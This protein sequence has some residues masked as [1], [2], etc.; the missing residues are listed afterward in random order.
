MS[1]FSGSGEQSRKINDVVTGAGNSS[2][3]NKYNDNNNDTSS[4]ARTTQQQQSSSNN[5]NGFTIPS[6]SLPK[7][8][9]AIRGIGEKF[10]ANPVTGTGSLSVPIYTSPGRSGFGPSLSLSY[11]SG[12]GNSPF[13]F[14]WSLSLPSITRKTS[15]GIPKYQDADESDVFIL[16]GAEDLVP[17][18]KKNGNG[19]FEK[20]AHRN[21][22]IDE[23]D[24]DG[25][26][27]RK[28]RPRTEGLFARIERWTHKTNGDIHWRSIS[29]D[30]ILTVYGKSR[31]SRIADPSDESGRVYSW[32]ICESY[33]D[34]GNA[35]VYE[36]AEEDEKGIEDDLLNI[37]ERN[38][39]RTANR[40][41]K[42]IFYGNRRPLLLDPTKA[43]F[44]KSHIELSEDDFS[45]ADWMFEVVFDY[46]EGH[47]K[48]IPFDSNIP[49]DEQHQLVEAAASAGSIWSGRPDTFSTYRSSFE[50]RTYRRCHRV[51]MFHH[52]R[53]L[54]TE[55]Y[56]VRSTEFDYLDFDYSSRSSSSFTVSDELNDKGSTRFASFIQSVVQ[57]GYLKDETRPIHEVNGVKYLI[58]IKKSIP[59]LEF[60]YSKCVI[61]HD[62]KDLDETS[63]ENLP[64]GIDGSGYQLVDLDG[65]GVSG[66]LTE[67]ADTWFYKPNLGDAKFGPIEVVRT[68]P[69]ISD[70]NG[71]RQQLMDLAG[72]GQLDL[73]EMR[74]TSPGFYE[75]THDRNW[76]N[77][78]PFQSIPNVS[79]NDPNLR[80]VDL[81]GDGHAD[82]LITENEVFTWYQSL[83]EKG[84]ESSTMVFQEPDEEKGPKLVLNESS[85]SIYLADMSG[86]GLSDLVRIKNGEVCY[87]PNL[88]YG[89]FGAKVTMDNSPWFDSPDQFDSKKIRLADIDGS[90]VTDI[91]YIG[92]T[93]D[94]GAIQIYFNQSGNRWSDVYHLGLGLQIDNHSSIQ[95]T[96]LFG[97]GTA[98]LVWSSPLAGHSR[99]SLRYLD[100]MGGTNPPDLT[101]GTKPHLLVKSVNNLGAETRV[102][103][104]SSTK[105]YLEDKAAGKPWITSMPFPVHVIERVE[106]YDYISR[107][108]FVTKYAYHHGYF[109]GIEQEFRGFG[110]VEQLDT[111]NFATLGNN[112]SMP[113][114]ENIDVES[115]IP[116]VLTKTWFHTGVYHGRDHVSDYFVGEYYR[117]PEL[118]Q[119]PTEA[120]KR[121]LDDT[122]MPAEL[123]VDEEYEACRALRGSMLRQE[124]FSRDGTEKE[125][126]PY[127]VTE[128]NFTIRTVQPRGRNRHTVFLTHEKEALTY[129]Y[130]RNPKDPRISHMMTL[131]VDDFGNVLKQAQIGY[132][133]E[134]LDPDLPRQEDQLNQT[135]TSVIY[136]E[137]RVTKDVDKMDAYRTPLPCES[138][139]YE[140]TGYSYKDEV[141]RFIDSDFVKPDPTRPNR[142]ILDFDG[143]DVKYEDI[144]TSGKRRRPIEHIRTFYRKNDLS[145]ILSLEEMESLALPGDIY[146]LA[147][148]PGLI[149][150]VYRRSDPDQPNVIDNLLP[151]PAEVLEGHG[152]G[153]GGYVSSQE[154]KAD[155][156]F[157]GDDPDDHWW[158]PSCRI[159]FSPNND[160]TTLDELTYAVEHFYLPHR[161]KNPFGNTTIV[162]FDLENFLLIVKVEDP[163][164]NVVTVGGM[165][166]RLL[167]PFLVTNPN[168]NRSMVAFDVLG[169]VVG[170]AV[171]G[172]PDPANPEG[173]NLD[174][175]NSNLT[176]KEIRDHIIV[177][178][179]DPHSILRNATTRMIYD[180]FSYYNT[181]TQPHPKPCV[182]YAMVRETHFADPSNG[183]QQDTKIQH[184]FSYSDGF[185][186][187]IQKKIQAEIGP[188][189]L[190]DPSSP[191]ADPRWVGTG[192]TIF[193]NKG[194][195]VRQYEPFFSDTSDFEFKR[196]EGVSPVIFY[197]PVG[198]SVVVLHPNDTYEK[199]VFDNWNQVTSDV[200][201][202]VLLD[203]RTDLDVSGIVS[204][205]F[206]SLSDPTVWK[207]WYQK[208]ITDPSFS[209]DEKA[210]ARKTES[211]ANTPTTTFFDSLGRP[212][213]TFS[214][215]G[216]NSDGY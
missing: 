6:I 62:I 185:G 89:R 215:N 194:K 2:K 170:M 156:L 75:R 145:A 91:L 160:D 45:S 179:N 133:R 159:F 137:N 107:N 128:Q 44:R 126:N 162:T 134:S 50:I 200:N 1:F 100:L 118:E 98:C 14:G 103:Y 122:I 147:F 34:R 59:P 9:G 95:I 110:M 127:T 196:L 175:F 38:R 86:D 197:D 85:Q 214:H 130:E 10:A 47:Y 212:F 152:P 58:Y 64:T 77:F 151:I 11:D 15:K 178:L 150:A 191:I 79:W 112:D 80:L 155:G 57:S 12:S 135:T 193:N 173:D 117:E 208:R 8:G 84:F 73:V 49:E 166:Y 67:Q 81:T 157:P 171:M 97:N 4:P 164:G 88:G 24:R 136:T 124:V 52:F 210:A 172:K 76:E 206:A 74:G 92:A 35:T 165:D 43:S 65:E 138:V 3:N 60:E 16:S 209:D 27:V 83:A 31:K 5:N 182:V 90:G 20:D 199:I 161:Y 32:L 22:V 71:G 132:G 116:P 101:H 68:K 142:L 108:L 140:L 48:E 21:F 106:T 149:D 18:F 125:D 70:L 99:K 17:I 115:Y 207:T 192:W 72:D 131:E 40:Y 66:I 146:K 188:L 105:F 187:E 29:K 109:D 154:L 148:T 33:D 13:G 204:K 42:R 198:R 36:Y 168:Q 205:Y 41:I 186:R 177:P 102:K 123:T 113:D 111:E 181:K 139:T 153:N 30:N 158:V 211:H 183:N 78:V 195:P 119:D 61:N 82:I 56:L 7:G 169:M 28:Y 87:W 96:D 189:D 39:I 184:S 46:D 121:L 203:P 143:P 55:P 174:H 163:I 53:E 104:V 190:E 93:L 23:Q 25:Y 213:I 201:D 176:T 54:G 120:R 19:D 51:L 94:N 167:Q 216:L 141:G 37:N 26:T 114:A 129:N 63:L 180:L 202:T 69:S 144:P